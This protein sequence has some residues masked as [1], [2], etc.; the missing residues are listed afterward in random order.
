MFG[1]KIMPKAPLPPTEDGRLQNLLS[2]NL[3]DTVPEAAFDDLAALAAAVT[4]TPVCLIN[5]VDSERQWFKSH[6]GTDIRQT[7]RDFAFCGYTILGEGLFTVNDTWTDERFA[8]NPFVLEEPFIRFYA[9]I[10]LITPEGHAIGTL[11]VL[12][13][14]PHD[15]LPGEVNALEVL[16]R[17]V[18]G[19]IR[20][21]RALTG[22]ADSER[23]ARATVDALPAQIAIVDHAG[24]IVAANRT[25]P[26]TAPVGQNFI[27]ICASAAWL[28]GPNALAVAAGFTELLNGKRSE[29]SLE[30]RDL[31]APNRWSTVRGT[32]F[33]GEGPTRLVVS[34]EDVTEQHLASD[35]L[36]HDS[37]HDALTGLPNRLL[38]AEKVARCVAKARESNHPFAVLF[39][40]LDR[41]KV[42]NDS[43]GHAAGDFVLTTIADRIRDCLVGGIEPS[44]DGDGAGPACNHLVARM[45]G[46][47]F[48]I[49]LD[50][51]ADGEDAA[52]LA[53]CIMSAIAR[54][55]PFDGH[56][57]TVTASV[58]IVACGGGA[59]RYETAKDLIR[60]ADAAM[61]K[62][63]AA[64]K[65][66]YIVFDHDMHEEVVD[67]MRLESELRRAA[68]RGELELHYQPI[69]NMTDRSVRG[70]EALVRWRRDGELVEPGKF[71]PIAEETGLII[72]IGRWVVKDACRQLANWRVLGSPMA[73]LYMTVN[74][75]RKQL[76]DSRLLDTVRLALAEHNL[77]PAS[78]VLEITETALMSEPE[79]AREMMA[80]LK[81]LGVRLSVDD[82]GTGYSSLACLHRFPIDLLKFDRSFVQDWTDAREAAVI[83]TIVTL[84]HDLDL[85]VVAEGVENEEQ[86]MFLLASRCDLTQGYLYARPMVAA[87]AEAFV[88]NSLLAAV[89][90]ALAA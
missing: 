68:G 50:P 12:D 55:V 61:Y 74:V 79:V 53:S 81:Q 88:L 60:D 36:R 72:S 58:G 3:L 42:I 87:A 41:F 34:H 8:D 83:R 47:E 24:T 62:A 48:T 54:P 56:E 71:I 90:L 76:A 63:K 75:S 19:Q 70:F 52:I 46:D 43:L 80:S 18:M 20:L 78:L 1:D 6:H 86:A 66:R 37:R 89:P 33:P 11:C 49:L 67:R 69:L 77:P 31:T 44:A 64:G 5:L 38:F 4:G 85:T 40:D 39:L 23:F 28:Y 7:P 15:M 30:F 25:W 27:E 65:D 17:Q 57:L 21:R 29:F 51:A 10:P 59:V 84:A 45:G 9:G 32:R 35:R 22:L 82:F 2:Y 14:V 13:V 73:D 16:A 26:A